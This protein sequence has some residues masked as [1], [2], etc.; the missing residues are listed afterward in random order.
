MTNNYAQEASIERIRT[1]LRCVSR[2]LDALAAPPKP[3]AHTVEGAYGALPEALSPPP[4]KRFTGEFR[5]PRYA[6]T[7]MGALGD[8]SYAGVSFRRATGGPIGPRLILKPA[9]RLVFDVLREDAVPGEGRLYSNGGGFVRRS[10]GGIG[11]IA[12]VLSTPRI[13]EPE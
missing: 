9:K 4:G 1:V 12:Y 13:E 3:P 5:E 11:R 7:Y 8:G 6:E 10:D 2:E